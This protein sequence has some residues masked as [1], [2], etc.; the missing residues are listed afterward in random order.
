[1]TAAVELPPVLTP[2]KVWLTSVVGV[3]VAGL[4]YERI[5]TGQ[6]RVEWNR[7]RP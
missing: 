4:T 5:G 2:V 3:P 7:N 6:M 1:M